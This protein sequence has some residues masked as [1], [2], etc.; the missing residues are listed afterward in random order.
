[1]RQR[2]GLGLERYHRVRSALPLGAETSDYERKNHL[3]QNA[4][5]LI[6]LDR[7]F[8]TRC[9]GNFKASGQRRLPANRNICVSHI[10]HETA[11][12]VALHYDERNLRTLM[13]NSE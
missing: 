3:C 12:N 2:Q 7:V 10:N 11:S 8:M 4:E 1:M 5:K 13:N 9:H 6:Q